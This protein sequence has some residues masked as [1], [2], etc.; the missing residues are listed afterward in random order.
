MVAPWDQRDAS[1]RARV[2]GAVLARWLPAVVT[3]APF[4]AARA[5]DRDDRT[6]T[7]R[8]GLRRLA[9][10]RERDVL[11]APGGGASLV[12]R[13][14]EGQVKATADDAVIRRIARAIGRDGRDGQRDAIVEEYRPL[15]LHRGGADGRLL[16]ASSRADLDRWHRTGSR[17]AAVLGLRD[18]DVLLSAVPSGPSLAHL[19]VMHL[20]AG[21]GM[22]ALHA[23]GALVDLAGIAA[24]AGEVPT[25]V[26]A[27]PMA[28]AEALAAA[29]A[30][31]RTEMRAVHTVVVIGPPPDDAVRGAIQDAFQR[32]GADVRVRAL[33]GP[34]A[35]RTMWAECAVG[36]GLHTYPD[37]EVLEVLD[38]LDGT[39]TEGDGDL[40]VSSAGW[41]GTA[42]V[43]FQT[44]AWV[45]PLVADG[46]C[47]G[48]G[49]T[50]PRLVGE[51][52]PHAWELPVD[53][54]NHRQDHV[55]LRGV[56]AV[57]AG[58]PGPP[59]W[60]AELR[61]PTDRVPRDRLVVELSGGGRDTSQTMAR[62]E[63]ATG[64]APELH[65]EL[66]FSDIADA[67]AQVGGQLADR[68]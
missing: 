28:E 58:L 53:V 5:G 67:I 55:D 26:V 9:P 65:T 57:V 54:G 17:A 22:T 30:T 52:I 47:P 24:A 11:A 34:S 27:V 33:W 3:A 15:T 8:T 59:T 37:L 49:R 39:P 10:M 38:P 62:L 21:A 46:P 50:V 32:A 66:S 44:G 29:F 48:C 12:L 31:R 43:R 4:H 63:R 6:L 7:D 61:G 13:P 35:G 41:N 51:I 18:D 56:G 16:I 64:L 2:E 42:L 40:T 60:R 25:T 45:E 19:S 1:A 20:A 14:T 23:R 36:S 68:R